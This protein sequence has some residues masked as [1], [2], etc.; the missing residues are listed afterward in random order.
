M[1]LTESELR[2]F[3]AKIV[4]DPSG[5]WRWTGG[6]N[7]KG[8]G[9]IGLRKKGWLVHRL[10]FWLVNG[11]L[12]PGLQVDH[13]CHNEDRLCPG[14]ST[15]RHRVCVNPAHLEEVTNGENR[16]RTFEHFQFS[17]RPRAA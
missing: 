9:C 15:C 3:T 7:G 4:V 16:R 14:G 1:I 5:C 6:R 13:T 8:Y 17:S 11:Y 10:M 12:T 2:R